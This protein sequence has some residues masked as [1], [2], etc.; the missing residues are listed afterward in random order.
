MGSGFNGNFIDFHVNG[1][2]SLFKVAATGNVTTTSAGAYLFASRSKFTSPADGKILLQNNAATGFTELQFGGTTSSF[3]EWRVSG[4]TFQARL[5][6]NSA[7]TSISA[8]NVTSSGAFISGGTK[9]TTS[10]CSISSTTGGATAGTMTSG[11]TGTCTVV[12]TL[13]TAPNGW[14]CAASNR[15]AKT[16]VPTTAS[17]TTS[18]TIEGSTTTGDVISF[19]AMAY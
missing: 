3:P 2:A 11:T 7:D 6:D 14:H 15:T 9:F 16:A 13:P 17:S 18:C 19:L 12:I 4:A 1:G 8:A 5:A 10:G